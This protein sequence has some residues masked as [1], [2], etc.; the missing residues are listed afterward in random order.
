MTQVSME[1]EYATEVTE[2]HSTCLHPVSRHLHL[3]LRLHL[4]RPSSLA[5]VHSRGA[6]T[7]V[8]SVRA[9]VCVCVCL[10]VSV[11]LCVCVSTCAHRWLLG[12]RSQHRFASRMARA[13]FHTRLERRVAQNDLPGGLDYTLPPQQRSHALEGREYNAFM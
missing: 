7:E 2:R 1:L 12:Q 13:G 4:A 8:L 9:C 3:A 5:K 11:C 10:C 6:I